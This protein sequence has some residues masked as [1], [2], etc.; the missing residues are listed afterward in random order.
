MWR[1]FEEG[2]RLLRLDMR[3]F[4]VSHDDQYAVFLLFVFNELFVG[5]CQTGN[6]LVPEF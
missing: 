1:G 2:R 5:F 3:D 4:A 6:N